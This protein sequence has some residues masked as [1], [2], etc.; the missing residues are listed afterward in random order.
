MLSFVYVYLDSNLIS[1]FY[2]QS[3]NTDII[4]RSSNA[5]YTLSAI[6]IFI[7][8]VCYCGLTFPSQVLI[9]IYRINT[10]ELRHFKIILNKN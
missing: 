4:I 5:L 9:N 10:N 7:T 1:C 3:D 6:H 2:Q 8:F